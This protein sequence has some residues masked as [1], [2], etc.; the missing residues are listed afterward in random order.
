MKIMLDLLRSL[1][2][3]AAHFSK[4]THTPPTFSIPKHNDVEGEGTVSMINILLGVNDLFLEV[5]E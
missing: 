5:G 1:S 3:P 4:E 2:I